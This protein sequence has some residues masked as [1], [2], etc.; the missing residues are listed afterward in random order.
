[1]KLSFVTL[2][3]FTT[4]RFAGNPVAIVELPAQHEQT[5]TQEQKLLIAKE[6][7]LSETVILHDTATDGVTPVDIFTSTAE[8]TWAGHPTIGSA[9][10][11]LQQ[12][13]LPVQRLLTKA[14]PIPISSVADGKVEAEIPHNVRE[15]K[16]KVHSELSTT[17]DCP[18]VSIVKGMTF[19]L[20]K[21]PDLATLAKPH[22]TGIK[23]HPYEPLDLDSGWNEGLTGT[24]YYCEQG[25]NE[26]GQR[27]LR[28]RML[29]TREDPATGSAS[30]AL[31]SYLALQEP[32]EKGAGPF[33]YALTQGVEMG[34]RSEIGVKIVRTAKGDAI[35]SV[36]LS[37]TAVKVMEGTIEI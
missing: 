25:V 37:G 18:Q 14:G 9:T 22:G 16:I 17:G 29:C 26:K 34:S 3:V 30:C 35:E 13:A 36:L 2:D 6:F 11:L 33:E 4:N 32:A 31:A 15:H 23:E 21:V 8:I 28:T 20:V 19:I 12:K 7:N 1:M 24:F 5:L 10:Y 27:A